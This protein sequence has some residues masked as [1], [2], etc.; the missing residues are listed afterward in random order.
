L[1]RRRLSAHLARHLFTLKRVR[2]TPL[3]GS[4]VGVAVAL[5]V[6][7]LAAPAAS[8]AATTLTKTRARAAA[9]QVAR[10]TCSAMP[11]CRG[12]A[13]EP[14]RRCARRSSRRVDCTI[15][16]RG[17]SGRSSAGLVI[18]TRTRVGRIEVGVAVPIQ[19]L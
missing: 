1:A 12:F 10:E 13:V 4:T 16:F 15:R 17:V 7:A 6:V 2:S 9:V 5:A 11:W 19:P 18:V 14:A 8:S 3:A